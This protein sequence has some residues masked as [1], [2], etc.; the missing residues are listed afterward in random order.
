MYYQKSKYK[1][2][3]LKYFFDAGLLTKIYL[4]LWFAIS[5]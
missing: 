1:V 4:Y 5:A 3:M 2:N